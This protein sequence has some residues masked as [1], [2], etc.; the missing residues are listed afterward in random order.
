M[1]VAPSCIEES[2]RESIKVCHLSSSVIEEFFMIMYYS[3]FATIISSGIVALATST[4]PP[5]LS[6][7]SRVAVDSS[8][9]SG[10]PTELL[11]AL[12]QYRAIRWA[13]AAHML[14]CSPAPLTERPGIEADF[15]RPHVAPLEEA[16]A[17]AQSVKRAVAVRG[18]S[19]AMES[20]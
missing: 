15:V 9:L 20:R 13:T 1:R 18:R 17:D 16:F 4:A 3:S 12:S 10:Q 14:H 2:S 6:A 11:S 19:M 5:D 8:P 7:Q